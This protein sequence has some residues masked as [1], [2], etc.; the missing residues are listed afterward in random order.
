MKAG[1]REATEEPKL[2]PLR[3]CT[4]PPS[5]LAERLDWIRAE[6]L[7]HARRTEQLASG[8]AWELEEV[9]GL[10]EKVDLLIALERE[11]CGGIVFERKDAGAPGLLRLEVRGVD[12]KAA[13]F[14]S[15]RGASAEEQA[16]RD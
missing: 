7:P 2:D 4:L 13:V 11:C 16:G 5:G 6:I 12:P 1:D 8:F 3:V 14:R 9:P 15:L 10:A